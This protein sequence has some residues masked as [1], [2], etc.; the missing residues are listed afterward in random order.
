M[1]NPLKH[2]PYPLNLGLAR[3]SSIITCTLD[4]SLNLVPFTFDEPDVIALCVDPYCDEPAIDS[5]DV[6]SVWCEKCATGSYS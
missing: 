5:D 4:E 2:L 1:R 3:D 6:T